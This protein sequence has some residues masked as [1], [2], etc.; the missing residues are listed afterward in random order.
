MMKAVNLEFE[1]KTADAVRLLDEHKDES[2]MHKE[3][4]LMHFFEARRARGLG[5]YLLSDE[6]PRKKANTPKVTQTRHATLVKLSRTVKGELVKSRRPDRLLDM[7]ND[8]TLARPC[9]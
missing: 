8:S 7:V 5:P 4:F 6:G 2:P 9:W 1:G 3:E